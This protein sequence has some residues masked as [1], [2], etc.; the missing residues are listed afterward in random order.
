M[1]LWHE[2]INSLV[3]SQYCC[4]EGNANKALSKL[5]LKSKNLACTFHV[6][7][8][9]GFCRILILPIWISKLSVCPTP[10]FYLAA[11]QQGNKCYLRDI[12]HFPHHPQ[13]F[14]CKLKGDPFQC[15]CMQDIM[16]HSCLHGKYKGWTKVHGSE[17]LQEEALTWNS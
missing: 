14:G 3:G 5:H 11:A 13:Y 2:G 16:H 4:G 9:Q 12:P 7:D 6:L 15:Q 17:W 1:P 8:A 10:P